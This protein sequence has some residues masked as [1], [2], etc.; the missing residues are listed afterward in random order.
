MIELSVIICTHNP[1]RDYLRRVLD[2]L[3]KQSLSMDHWELLLVDNASD[4]RISPEWDLSW[5]PNARHAIESVLGL[6]LARMRGIRE[7]RADLLVFVDDD[8]VL[9]PDYLSKAVRIK[10]EWPMLGVWGSGAIIPEFEKVPSDHLKGLLPYLALRE[11]DR[12]CWGNVPIENSESTPWGAGLCVRRNVAT[13]Y[14]RL[15]DDA[16]IRILGR[17]GKSLMGFEDVEICFVACSIG[18][19]MGVFPELRLTHLIRKER[20]VENYLLRLV[21]D[22]QIS[23]MLLNFKWKGNLP[24]T[25]ISLRKAL[26]ILKAMIFYHGLRRRLY[27]V[28]LRAMFKA[29]RLIEAIP[30]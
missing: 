7:A 2:A 12:V 30:R 10:N 16:S 25:R 23:M 5:H 11:S 6:A 9:D 14:L 27:F 13:N 21:E 28:N 17:R 8:N 19:G 15:Y 1:R 20:I 29:K 4:V 24:E 26:S 22:T 18:S 3:G